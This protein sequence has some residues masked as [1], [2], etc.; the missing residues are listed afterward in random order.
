MNNLYKVIGGLALLVLVILLW[1]RH[2]LQDT[3][4]STVPPT[5][6]L[7]TAAPPVLA[8]LPAL[9]PRGG[10]AKPEGHEIQAGVKADLARVLGGDVKLPVL[11]PAVVERYLERHQRSAQSLLGAFRATQ[12]PDFL[13]EAA[14]R[15]PQDP[16]IQLAVLGHNL[17]PEQR[18]EWL[19]RFK[20]SAPD[21]SL[22]AYLSAQE[23]FAA[24]DLPGAVADLVESTK[25]PHFN[26]YLLESMQ[27]VQELLVAGGRSPILAEAEAM[28][29]ADMGHLA[30][31]KQLS[32]QL[33][34]LCQQYQTAGDPD[35]AGAVANMGLMLAARLNG[36]REGQFIIDKLVG[37]TVEN[38]VWS[39]FDPNASS[40]YPGLTVQARRDELARQREA[41][42]NL[43]TD[44]PRT[45]L[46]CSEEEITAYLDRVKVLGEVEALRW[47]KSKQLSR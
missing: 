29:S 36:S 38:Q 47:L 22:A 43:T 39:L 10:S 30:Q 40:H 3:P 18:R 34:Q 28:F 2:K 14:S 4:G 44:F 1:P 31:L 7:Q 42:K 9:R 27:N 37:I 32:T 25:R 13:K 6:A 26:P 33:V 8:R 12:N 17:F 5:N 46:A 41:I 16:M 20:Q 15:Y 45:L 21:N 35:S 19:E 24:K 11:D 23:H